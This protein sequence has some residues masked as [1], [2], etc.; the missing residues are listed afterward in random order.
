VNGGADDRDHE[1]A[2]GTMGSLE[3]MKYVRTIVR[4]K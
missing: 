3:M 2:A 4:G 1:R